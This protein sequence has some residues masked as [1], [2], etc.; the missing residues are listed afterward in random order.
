M[1]FIRGDNVAQWLRRLWVRFH[2]RDLSV[3][4][5][6]VFPCVFTCSVRQFSSYL[7]Q[8]KNMHISWIGNFKFSVF[9]W[10]FVSMWPWDELAP[11][12]GCTQ[13]LLY[14]HELRI[15]SKYWERMD[16]YS[17]SHLEILWSWH[18]T[19]TCMSSTCGRSQWCNWDKMQIS[20]LVFLWQSRQN[21]LKIPEWQHVTHRHRLS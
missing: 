21:C 15:K 11:C 12:P 5:F 19:W 13:S 2:A 16:G 10:L 4:S 18:L 14:D 17:Y 8:S 20:Q 1:V 7:P 9:E 6:H 3:W